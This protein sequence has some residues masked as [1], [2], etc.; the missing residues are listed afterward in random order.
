MDYLAG[1]LAN[2]E[3]AFQALK[4]G[5]LTPELLDSAKVTAHKLA[6]N[7]MMYGFP[8]MGDSAREL[9]NLLLKGPSFDTA[10]GQ[11][12]FIKLITRIEAIRSQSSQTDATQ[13]E[14]ENF[15]PDR[16]PDRWDT[17]S[18][19]TEDNGL[20]GRQS[21]VLLI[22]KDPWMIQ[23]ITNMLVP[24]HKVIGCQHAH[25]AMATAINHTPDIIIVEQ[26]L[27]DMSGVDVTRF[28]R[29]VD[30]LK[31]VPVVM[32]MTGD[33]PADIVKAVEAGVTDCFESAFEVLPLIAH[34]RE[35]LQKQQFHILIV[36]DDKAVCDLLAH[37]FES[38][39]A[40]ADRV[41]DGIEALEY[42]RTNK[43]D[44]IILDRMMPRL[45]GGAVLYQ[46]QQEINLKSIPVMLVTAMAN[47]DDVITW[48]KRGAID[49]I[50]KPF[51]PDEVVLRAL[52]HL[53]IEQD[54]A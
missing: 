17:G 52:R 13:F 51:N 30:Q 18:I 3:N 34:V 12:L 10:Q 15:Q 23:L 48:L 6:G 31:M 32:I 14:S 27:E 16:T 4:G 24:E 7:A 43:P 47:R 1:S 46:I 40:R 42:L 54:A 50:T 9:E 45:E 20:P 38:Y 26:D 5:D 37:R 53:R 39:G 11:S 29:A 35:I 21:S 25:E 28:I 33:N 8:E 41:Y 22:H 49:Y 36:D 19:K 44:L 2:L